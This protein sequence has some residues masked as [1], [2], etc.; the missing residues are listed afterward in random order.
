MQVLLFA[1]KIMQVKCTKT[2]RDGEHYK[3]WNIFI[4]LVPGDMTG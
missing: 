1:K 2:K 3:S 4:A